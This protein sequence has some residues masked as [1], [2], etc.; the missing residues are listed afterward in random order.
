MIAAGRHRL[1]HFVRR[2]TYPANWNKVRDTAN[3]LVDIMGLGMVESEELFR[4]IAHHV[5]NT[6][7]KDEAFA[8]VFAA[9]NFGTH[10]AAR[11]L[12]DLDGSVR[13]LFAIIKFLS[14]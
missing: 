9:S 12:R 14:T 2:K 5:T 11:T 13:C 10:F 6:D 8:D 7:A 4:E 1:E 3:D